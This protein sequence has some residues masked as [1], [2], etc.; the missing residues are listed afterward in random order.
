MILGFA[1]ET[2]SISVLFGMGLLLPLCYV[3]KP[4]ITLLLL[5]ATYWGA[6]VTSFSEKRRWYRLK[7]TE[8]DGFYILTLIQYLDIFGFIKYNRV[9]TKIRLTFSSIIVSLFLPI[10]TIFFLLEIDRV[11]FLALSVF[12]ITTVICFQASNASVSNFNNNVRTRFLSLFL[13][14]M[15]AM[16]GLLIPTIGID[17]GTGAQRFSMGVSELFG[18]IDFIIVVLGLCC[19]GE[20]LYATSEQRAWQ[21]I[22]YTR[23]ESELIDACKP[24]ELFSVVPLG[25]PFSQ[26]SAII[27]GAFTIYGISHSEALEI[28]FGFE[29]TINTL[30]V[31]MTVI[32]LMQIVIRTVN[33]KM[34]K[35]RKVLFFPAA[36][37]PIITVAA[38]VGAYS[39]NYRLFDMFML[40]VFGLLGFIMRQL[41]FPITPLLVCAAFGSRLEAAYRTPFSWSPLTASFY[42]LSAV[43]IAIYIKSALAND[44]TFQLEQQQL[45]QR[46]L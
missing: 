14:A 1:L 33:R 35:L 43:V 21:K 2:L 37:Y 12:C 16:T 24:A 41:H 7:V 20:I 22:K 40:I 36:I 4:E 9:K 42:I 8:N 30:T 32:L 3:L 18:G 23:I 6:S 46:R 38:F 11:E 27:V 13:S 15:S 29:N 31:L 10:L 28:V 17:I 5:I 45:R 39:I 44:G 25:I 34:K 26:A 19:L